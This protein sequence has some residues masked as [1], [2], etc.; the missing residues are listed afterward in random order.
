ML[1]MI[2][3]LEQNE[4]TFYPEGGMI[5]I[6]SALYALAIKKG[7]QFFFNT[8]VQQIVHEGGQV[9]GIMAGDVVDESRKGNQQCRCIL[10]VP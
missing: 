5:S 3:H 6:P 10:C 2:P 1:S 9:K 7:V 4:G 8:P